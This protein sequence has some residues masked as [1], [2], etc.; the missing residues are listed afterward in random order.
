MIADG[1]YLAVL[2]RFEENL[3]VLTI[4]VDDGGTTSSEGH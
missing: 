4:T 3:A 1:E 2:D